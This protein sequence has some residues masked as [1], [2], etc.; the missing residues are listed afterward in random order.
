M[1]CPAFI[2]RGGPVR[3]LTRTIKGKTGNRLLDS[4]SS[5]ELSRILA[6]TTLVEL[7]AGEKVYQPGRRIAAAYFPIDCVLAV[8]IRLV[9]GSEAELASIGWEGVLGARS[10]Q[11]FDRAPFP[12]YCTVPGRAL[13]LPLQYFYRFAAPNSRLWVR[14]LRYRAAF[15][16][17]V[18]WLSACNRFHTPQQRCARWLLRTHDC[19]PRDSFE[20][21]HQFL[22]R[23][24]G[25]QRPA[26][27]LCAGELQRRGA[28]TYTRGKVTI[29]NRKV[30]ESCAC[31]CYGR[32]AR[33]LRHTL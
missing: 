13:R 25:I 19:V 29:K 10:I 28:I 12:T 1:G 33:E 21:T 17:T 5:R 24:L 18:V 8:V 11:G 31:E 26:A 30:L 32:I 15:M 23:L 20:I 2:V 27:T 3:T 4:L 22:A 9:D 7:T 14:A 6:H 16:T